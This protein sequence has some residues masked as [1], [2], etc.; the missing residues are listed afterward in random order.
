[1]PLGWWAGRD[2]RV[3]FTWKWRVLRG[4]GAPGVTRRAPAFQAQCESPLSRPSSPAPAAAG[5]G[6]HARALHGQL[7]AAPRG[8]E[9][10]FLFFPEDRWSSYC[11]SSLAAQN[12]CTSKLHCPATPEQA[13]P[14]GSLGS[15]SCCSLLRGLSSGCSPPLLPAPAGNPN[16]AIFTVDAKTSEVRAQ[17]S[18][19]AMGLGSVPS[20][21]NLKQ[22]LMH[23]KCN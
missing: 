2:L 10:P 21:C 19:A 12:I 18:D 8:L 14:T 7:L 1:M 9:L 15:T 3:L 16:K 5:R 23:F 11:L 17:L 13:D 4:C 22:E 20:T 6:P